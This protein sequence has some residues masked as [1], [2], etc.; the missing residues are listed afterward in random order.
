MEDKKLI[1]AMA[2]FMYSD[3]P[4]DDL[5]D[6]D[7]IGVLVHTDPKIYFEATTNGTQLNEIV[8]KMRVSVHATVGITDDE[9]EWQ[10]NTLKQKGGSKVYRNK[11][12]TTAIIK[13][14]AAVLGVEYGTE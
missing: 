7:E 13:C 4:I 12:R 6:T 9:A 2:K 1:L 10:A 8:E 3:I 11:D 14:I 5:S